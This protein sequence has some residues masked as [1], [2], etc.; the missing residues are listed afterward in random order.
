MTPQFRISH[1]ARLTVVGVREIEYRVSTEDAPYTIM[2]DPL[3]IV[4]SASLHFRTV[5]D[6]SGAKFS[7]GYPKW[8]KGKTDAVTNIDSGQYIRYVIFDQ[9]S[10]GSTDYFVIEAK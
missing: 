8:L 9:A 6:P 10:S 2:L 1:T 7:S 3:S 4:A 5:L